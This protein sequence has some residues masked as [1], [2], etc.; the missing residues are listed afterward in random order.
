MGLMIAETKA[1][2]S[3][4]CGVIAAIYPEA[5]DSVVPENTIINFNSVSTNATSVTWFLDKFQMSSTNAWNYQITPGLHTLSLVATNGVCSDT[6]TVVYFAAG[7][8]QSTDT[9]FLANYGTSR[10]NEEGKVIDKTLDGGFVIGA[11]QYVWDPCGETGVVIKLTDKGCIQWSKKIMTGDYCNA[12]TMQSLYASKDTNYYL[13]VNQYLCKLDK[14]GNLVWQH[15]YELSQMDYVSGSLITGDPQGNIYMVSQRGWNSLSITKITGNGDVVWNK[16]YR[17]SHYEAPVG[18]PIETL[19]PS[20]IAVLNDNLFICGN[21]YMNSQYASFLMKL[22]TA[23]G[24]KAWQ[25]GFTDPEFPGASIFGKLAL[26]DTL[27]M[28]TGYAQGQ[29]AMLIDQQGTERK[30][31]KVKFAQ[32]F[33]PNGISAAADSNGHIY[34]MSWTEQSLPLQPGY[35]Y[36]SNLVE[37]DTFMNKYWGITYSNYPRDH[38]TAAAATPDGYF[39]A[40][41]IEYGNTTEGVISSRN[42]WF[43]RLDSAISRGFCFGG[44][45]TYDLTTKS[46]SRFNF[47]IL[48]DSTLPVYAG[49]GR[50]FWV[51]EGY[52]GAR[53]TCPDFIDSCSYLKISGPA[54]LCNPSNVYTFRLH[55]NKKC[56]TPAAWNLPPGVTIMNETDSTL[57]VKFSDF[58]KFT[59][60]ATMNGC[61]PVK[62]SIVVNLIPKNKPLNIGID[63]FICPGT[64]IVLRAGKE[65]FSY[66]WNDNSTD[67]LLT[68][69]QGGL[70]WIEA[71]DSCGNIL[72]DSIVISQNNPFVDG[73]P[74]RIKCNADTLHLSAPAG[75]LS[76]QWSN[77]Y[78]INI[79]TGPSVIVNPLQDTAYYLK[80]EKLPGCFGF[81]TIRVTV[82]TSPALSL[83]ADQGFCEG[84]SAVLTPATGFSQYL[85]SNGSTEPRLAVYQVG[86]YSVIGTAANGCRSYDTLRI[87]SIWKNPV[88]QLQDDPE[89]CEGTTRILDPG[90]QFSTYLWNNLSAGQT[91]PV[92]TT[93]TYYVAV[94]DQNGCR[95]SDTVRII[96]MVPPP[97][98]FFPA[99]TAICSYGTLTLK[100]VTNFLRY[101]W[102]NGSG[103]PA[104]DISSPGIYWLDATNFKG[105]TGRDSVLVRPKECLIGF[106]IPKAFTPNGDGLNEYFKPVIGGV[107]REY[108]FTIYD[109]WG[110][111]VFTT[112]DPNKGWD[113]KVKGTKP[114]SNVFVWACWLKLDGEVLRVERGTVVVL[115]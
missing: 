32:N 50:G 76:Y 47:D 84:D 107:I 37:I 31:L 3:N 70:Y 103:N 48:I 109:R 87:T 43:L 46:L 49:A 90:N 11:V 74:D 113:G 81:D 10:Y 106:Y 4:P 18:Q 83:G 100:P 92:S 53:Y 57:A 63:T 115:R 6:T 14:N 82:L 69:T 59:L 34:M 71:T 77:N 45:S 98:N 86:S 16:L 23:T 64:N 26:Y 89:L 60:S 33:G 61:F 44:G 96:T 20:G 21:G 24:A 67:S 75:F 35:Q 55:R 15:R 112:R 104:I 108:R 68:V 114:D 52:L 27:L 2:S 101:S 51:T 38:F 95:G 39:G 8:P 93:G 58:G 22:S 28:V 85:W 9:M 91:L 54:S 62:D 79:T 12:T 41:G 73:G 105:C 80:A 110:N 13:Q 17:M 1:Q 65:F 78:N 42:V 88:V 5:K 72:R 56:I 7:T 40:T 99:D 66:K 29:M 111:A 25:Y 19:I 94:T 36:Y 102:S 97:A 30:T